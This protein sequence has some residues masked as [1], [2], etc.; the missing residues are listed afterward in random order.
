MD[1]V[2][3][4]CGSDVFFF[5]SVKNVYGFHRVILIESFM[6]A[7]FSSIKLCN[8]PFFSELFFYQR[9]FFSLIVET[10]YG[11][12]KREKKPNNSNEHFF[13]SV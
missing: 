7:F 5:F 10:S 4:K 3:L 11:N 2:T 13:S 8:Q 1:E 12:G 6:I 9:F